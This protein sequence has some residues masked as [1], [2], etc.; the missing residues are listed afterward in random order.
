MTRMKRPLRIQSLLPSVRSVPSVVVLLC[1]VQWAAA[2]PAPGLRLAIDLA[3]R[4][5][6]G[7][8][9]V[10]FRRLAL[11]AESPADRGAFEW[12]AAREHARDGRT[13]VSERMLDRAED[14]GAPKAP[15]LLLRAENAESADDPA[16]AGFFWSAFRTAADEAGAQAY[17]SR[18]LAAA[19]LRANRPDDALASLRASPRD[20]SAALAAVDAFRTGPRKRPLVGGLLGIVPGLGYAYS[21]EYANSARS[22]ILNGLFIAL[23]VL[24][25]EDDEWGAFGLAAFAEVT[26][27]T[28]SI[29]GGVDAAHRWNRRRMLD[30][31]HAV[32][33][34]A[35]WSVDYRALPV[36]KIGYDF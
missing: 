4:G 17:A 31:V 28:G 7:A 26:F 32:E 22:L 23:M 27:Y 25:A 10:E 2:D 19:H 34:D 29:Y 3:D 36:L 11:G 13:A 33:G 15:C 9:A 24:S 35:T 16:A 1:G 21:G 14:S 18:R 6:A 12:A 20:E 30:T 8:A 5:D